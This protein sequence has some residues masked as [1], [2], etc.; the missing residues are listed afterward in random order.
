MSQIAPRAPTTASSLIPSSAPKG[1]CDH[2]RGRGRA[3]ACTQLLEVRNK[4]IKR[5]TAWFG[6]QPD[7]SSVPFCARRTGKVTSP[8]SDDWRRMYG[9]PVYFAEAF[10]NPSRFGGTCYRAAKWQLLGLTT[11]RGK[12]DETNK[13]NRPSNS[14]NGIDR[15]SATLVPAARIPASCVGAAFSALSSSVRLHLKTNNEPMRSSR[16]LFWD[17]CHENPKSPPLRCCGFG[18]G[19]RSHLRECTFSYMMSEFA[20]RNDPTAA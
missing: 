17:R 7:P 5:T 3:P 1:P 13:P 10:I 11:G 19:L 14:L 4:R 18:R 16:I 15:L 2:K 8:L 6:C 9:H 12:D 20:H